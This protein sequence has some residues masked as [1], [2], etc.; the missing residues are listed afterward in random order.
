MSKMKHKTSANIF[1]NVLI[2]HRDYVF[3]SR[4]LSAISSDVTRRRLQLAVIAF[5]KQTEARLTQTV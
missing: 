1:V 4:P 5:T 2:L 3:L